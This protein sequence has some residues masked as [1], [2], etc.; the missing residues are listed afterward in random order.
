MLSHF[1]LSGKTAIV[2]GGSKGIGLEVVR[3]LAEAGAAVAFTYSSTAP[4]EAE[5]LA[6][7]LSAANGGRAVRAYKADVRSREEVEAVVLR[8]TAD[9]GGRLD[10]LVANAGIAD[11]IRAEEYPEDKWRNLYDVNVHGAFWAAQAAAR[12][13]QKQWK[14]AGEAA[15]HRGSIIFTV[16]VSATL[17]NIPQTQAAYNSSKAALKHLAKSLA[18]EWV[19]YARVNSIS[20]VGKPQTPSRRGLG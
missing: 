11:H 8:A 2:T 12:V 5:R 16:S 17:V 6:A 18:V 7:E 1:N 20:P 4:A 3:G 13:F 15:P 19:D 9:L 10:I 14:A